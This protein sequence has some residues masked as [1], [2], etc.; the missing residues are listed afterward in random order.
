MLVS[1]SNW[2]TVP[3][4]TQL[5]K[6]IKDI[7]GLQVDPAITSPS[8]FIDLALREIIERMER[9]LNGNDVPQDGTGTAGLSDKLKSKLKMGRS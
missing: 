2:S 1:S 4:R 5:Y 8:Q 3:I 7:V 6:R 9:S